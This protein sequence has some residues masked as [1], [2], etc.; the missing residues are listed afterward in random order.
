MEMGT[1]RSRLDTRIARVQIRVGNT[2]CDRIIQFVARGER[3]SAEAY[4]RSSIVH[5]VERSM[6]RGRSMDSKQE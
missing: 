5:H 3:N 1:L 6:E 4:D 2:A